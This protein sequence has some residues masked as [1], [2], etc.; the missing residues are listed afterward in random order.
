M[1][2]LAALERRHRI[3]V[4]RLAPPPL[5]RLARWRQ[6]DLARQARG[7]D[8][9]HSFVSAIPLL[10]ALPRV[11]TIH[12]L[13]WRH[14][15]RENADLAHRL[16]SE[17]GPLRAAAVQTATEYSARDLRAR[18]LP[19]RRKVRVVPWGVAEPFVPGPAERRAELVCPGG[20]RAKK[21][22][23]ALLEGAARHPQR[24]AL[25]ATGA[26]TPELERC[27]A[28]ARELGVW[29]AHV[30]SL[31]ERELVERYRGAWAVA[32]LSRSEGF[33]LPILEAMACGTPVIVPEHSAQAEVAGAAGLRVDPL[34]PES[35]AA[36]LER[37]RRERA[38]LGARGIERAAQFSWQRTA[39][40]IEQLWR[41]LLG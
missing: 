12:E 27:A 34:D 3:E 25:L 39:E 33:G 23:A 35:V 5:V 19:G 20:A 7:L 37:A 17:L 40:G 2:T 26:S 10:G 32:L 22:L 21:G 15:E 36:A 30:E 24:P 1:E 41:E 38:E 4:V 16:W 28:R 9:L 29:L 11:Q 13:P 31:D 8:G 14:G 18:W 6:L